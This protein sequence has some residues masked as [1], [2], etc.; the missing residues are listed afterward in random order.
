MTLGTVWPSPRTMTSSQQQQQAVYLAWGPRIFCCIYV[1][2][3]NIEILL[4]PRRQDQIYSCRWERQVKYLSHSNINETDLCPWG[5]NNTNESSARRNPVKINTSISNGSYSKLY[6]LQICWQECLAT[7]DIGM[8]RERIK[9]LSQF[10]LVGPKITVSREFH[11]TRS[12]RNQQWNQETRL[13]KWACFTRYRVTTELADEC[14]ITSYIC[15][16]QCVRSETESK[17][18]NKPGMSWTF[19]ALTRL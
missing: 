19:S 2:N 16:Q 9:Y 5:S 13:H 3:E 8:V 7:V 12:I 18:P 14:W 15:S 17:R 10:I 1:H 6:T 11:L 4:S